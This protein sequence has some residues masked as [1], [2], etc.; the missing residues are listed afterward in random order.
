MVRIAWR[1][2][3]QRPASMLATFVALWFAV[4][5][6]T[7]CGAMLESGIRYHGVPTRYA[8]APVLVAATDL[9]ISSGHGEDRE[10][11]AFPLPQHAPLPATLTGTVATVPGVAAVVADVAVP[12]SIGAAAVE[13]H[14]WSAARLT[15]Y[16]LRS[17]AAPAGEH[18]VV[19]DE[20]LASALG[21]GMGGQVPLGLPGGVQSF[22]V[23]GIAAASG[24]SPD[25]ATVF[26]TDAETATLSGGT[27]QVL[28]VFLTPGSD[29][30]TVADA[31]RHQLKEPQALAGA[32]PRV[33]TGRDRG[34]VESADVGNGREFVIA[35]SAVFGGMTLLIA[36]LVIAGTVGLSVR[37]RLRDIA[38]LRAIA[39][40][41]RQVR[42][43]VV[44]EAF[45]L[46]VLAAA[47]GIWPGLAAADWLR[48]Q[49]VDHG[50]VPD[51]LR[52]HLSWLPPLVAAGA[53]VLVAVVAA[54][55]ASL[56][57]SR[58]RPT[59]ALAET[60]VERG[61]L[62]VLRSL[63]GV[64]A[65][66]GGVFLCSLA[67][68][69]NG[70][71][72]ASISVATV[73]TLVVAVALLAPV[74]IRVATATVGRLLVVTGVTGRLAVANTAATARQLSAVVSSL[75]L[76]VALGGSLWF[77][78]TSVEHT[79]AQQSSAG[80]RAGWVALPGGAGLP[81][82]L[83]AQLRGSDGVSAATGVVTGTV[84]GRYDYATDLSAQGVDP[85]GLERTLDLGVTAGDLSGLRGDTVAVDTLTASSLHLH[86]GDEFTGW[87]G[88]GAP[89]RL[90]VVALYRR[91]LGFA[92]L[93][94]P[95]DT[96][97]AHSATGRDSA[98]FLATAAD[99]PGDAVRATLDRLAPGATLAPRDAYQVAVSQN[100]RANAWTNRMI[101][102]VLLV[103]V[104]IAAVNTLV[105]ATLAR[106]REIGVLRLS[107]TTRAQVLRM[108]RLE[109]VLLLGLALLL[110][111]AIAAGT[112][113]PMVKGLTGTTTPLHPAGRLG[114]G[115]R[116][117][118]PAR[119]PGHRPTTT[120]GTAYP[121]RRRHR[122]PG[123]TQRFPC[124]VAAAPV[125]VRDRRVSRTYSVDCPEWTVDGSEDRGL[126]VPAGGRGGPVAPGTT[127]GGGLDGGGAVAEL[128]EL[129]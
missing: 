50:L 51:T 3:R 60:V 74:L 121:P 109:Q 27:V 118:H 32:Y 58:I 43:M 36:I 112:L 15:P 105:M 96:L 26:A 29:R 71:S 54:W 120:P 97:L 16:T 73:F 104:G 21:V 115:A 124:S 77:V 87:Y 11:E 7:A 35:I 8:A 95:H 76:A 82:G 64:I 110:G 114:R 22:T 61:G 56:R 127:T 66:A 40:T 5:V 55:L 62:G 25:A 53:A 117:R 80:V 9:R 31:V 19:L 69:V 123:V 46:G 59:Q 79:A 68:S 103:Y 41:P 84:F 70:D 75:V 126:A 39:A 107:G 88:D 47:A 106:R 85:A 78:Q 42:R 94:L 6:V 17:G 63:L 108:V 48:G 65:L 12:A 57:A 38:L 128:A 129:V 14:P 23:T 89:A 81:P 20:R 33:F 116:G 125:R 18:Q 1:M 102:V 72:A 37:Q 10:V 30:H 98:V 99:Q 83:A 2:L 4:V 86:V 113:L 111:A 34:M 119:R 67:S 44:T 100:L 45:V 28:G 92:A 101:T 49:Y 24:Q 13:V 122:H 91:G 93:T 52:T 90:R